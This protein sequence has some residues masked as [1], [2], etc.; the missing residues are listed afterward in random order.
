MK[1]YKHNETGEVFAYEQSDIDKVNQ[2]NAGDTG[3]ID[4]VFSKIRDNLANCT[5]MT[6][7]AV[8]EHLNP[9]PPPPVVPAQVT[10]AQ[11]KAALV[12]AG[13]WPAVLDYVAKISDP[14]DRLLAEIALNDTVYWRRESPFLKECAK[15][16]GLSEDELDDL[17]TLAASIE[18]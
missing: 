18:L 8:E 3:G 1:Y 6:A 9:P 13:H 14:T 7:A 4:P 10:R 16:I 17:F 11:G 15:A 12:Q 5:E 2:T